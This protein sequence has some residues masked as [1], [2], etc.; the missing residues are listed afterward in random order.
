M[1]APS[2]D[3]G[4]EGAVQALAFWPGKDGW[5]LSPYLFG[6]KDDG[7][8]HNLHPPA[9]SICESGLSEGRIERVAHA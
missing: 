5:R 8:C 4:V 1:A 2:G 6:W 7:V 3:G 9:P